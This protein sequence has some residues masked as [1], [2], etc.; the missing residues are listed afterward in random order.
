MKFKKIW[1]TSS[2]HSF[3]REFEVLFSIISTIPIIMKSLLSMILWDF[4]SNTKVYKVTMYMK[5]YFLRCWCE[6]C[7]SFF[8]IWCLEMPIL[9]SPT[10]V[11]VPVSNQNVFIAQNKHTHIYIYSSKFSLHCTTAKYSLS[12]PIKIVKKKFLIKLQLTK[13]NFS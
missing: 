2:F 4:V 7:L 11:A 13:F 8:I 6:F 1:V 5:Q 3:P 12:L 10:L 9:S